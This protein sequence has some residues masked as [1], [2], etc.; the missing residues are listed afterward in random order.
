MLADGQRSRV[1]HVDSGIFW[2]RLGPSMRQAAPLALGWTVFAT[3]CRAPVFLL[4]APP[5]E[6]TAIGLS[7]VMALAVTMATSF[8]LAADLLAT[9][10]ATIPVG[11]F[12]PTMAGV[13]R[14]LRDNVKMSAMAF[15]IVVPLLSAIWFLGLKK[16]HEAAIFFTGSI[17]L[18]VAML[19]ASFDPTIE[20]ASTDQ[21]VD[22]K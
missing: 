19:L 17:E 15:T 3:A 14:L 1:A 18:F 21:E 11:T 6:P 12:R 10:A 16:F 13:I 7:P 2:S 5:Q 20:D 8:L 4:V 22:P 9:K